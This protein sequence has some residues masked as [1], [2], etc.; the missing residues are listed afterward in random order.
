MLFLTLQYGWGPVNAR[1]LH[2]C[3]TLSVK[4]KSIVKSAFSAFSN[5]IDWRKSSFTSVSYTNLFRL[6]GRVNIFTLPFVFY[7]SLPWSSRASYSRGKNTQGVFFWKHFATHWS[8]MR[9]LTNF[10]SLKIIALPSWIY[11]L[12]LRE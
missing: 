10:P 2:F 11:S 7:T 4:C 5:A 3:F 12:Q 1:P 9:K 6:R 8:V